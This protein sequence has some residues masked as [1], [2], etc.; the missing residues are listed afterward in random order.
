[1]QILIISPSFGFPQNI[2]KSFIFAQTKRFLDENQ[3]VRVFVLL[4]HRKEPDHP[5]IKISQIVFETEI[6]GV[7]VYYIRF[8]SFSN[9]GERLR[10]NQ[11]SAAWS[12]LYSLN[13][14]KFLNGF[15]PDVILAHTL[16]PCSYT[17]YSLGKL[18]LCP[19]VTITHGSDTTVPFYAHHFR[20][21]R[22]TAEKAGTVICIS[23][24]LYE[25]LRQTRLAFQKRIILNGFSAPDISEIPID[26]EDHSILFVGNLI[27]NKKADILL[28]AF[29]LLVKTYPD[30]KLTIIGKGTEA[31]Y[32]HN[33]A[34]ELGVEEGVTFCGEV[35]HDQVLK[36]MISHQIFVLPSI[37]EGFG[38]VYL[39]A[40]ACGC[41]TVGTEGEGIGD[42]II[43]G[44]N[45]F[46][47]PPDDPEKLS[48]LLCRCFEMKDQMLSIAEK[49]FQDAHKQT[50]STN[51]NQFLAL[52]SEL[53]NGDTSR[54]R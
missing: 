48:R 38:I 25:F 40:M 39:E 43:N 10:I 18:F 52:F 15:K 50:W 23:T 41:L 27:P 16:G 12:V 7:I 4:P 21:L 42:F 33:L 34:K 22:K 46:L 37:R 26:K 1:M 54:E 44:E 29:Q 13:R 14:W 17:A 5:Y 47:I 53:G 30:S 36:Y 3:S 19:V 32:L 11:Q 8:S 45:G 24:K 20:Y 49:G 35:P 2:S 6:E 9:I 31:D 28:K 51:V